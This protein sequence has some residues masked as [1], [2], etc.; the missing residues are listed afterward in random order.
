MGM[1]NGWISSSAFDTCALPILQI[2]V[3][4][5]MIV[6]GQTFSFSSPPLEA[7]PLHL[8]TGTLYFPSQR[9]TLTRLTLLPGEPKQMSYTQFR[10]IM[11]SMSSLTQLRLIGE[12]TQWPR[13]EDVKTISMPSPKSLFLWCVEDPDAFPSIVYPHLVIPAPRPRRCHARNIRLISVASS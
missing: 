8:T 13:M 4:R 10:D 7:R 2:S 11:T 5:P 1:W 9:N 6:T 3:S 12:V